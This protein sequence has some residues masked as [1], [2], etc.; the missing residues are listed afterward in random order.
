LNS[1]S[2][3]T[4]DDEDDTIEVVLTAEEMRRLSWAVREAYT[5]K[6]RHR[7][8]L[9]ALGAALVGIA[10]GI[11][12]SNAWR[13]AALHPLARRVTP[14]A[15]TTS[16]PA[17]ASHPAV[18][19]QAQMSQAPPVPHVTQV[20]QAS[21]APHVTLDPPV[22][23]RNPFDPQEVFEFPGGTTKAEARQKVTQLLLQ[24]AIDRRG[25]GT[26]AAD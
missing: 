14:A 11:A 24:R 9:V 12:A 4:P 22:R 6:R 21:Q 8:W 20:S 15:A 3:F 26:Q 2:T 5:S 13:P 1:Q 17:P 19:A 16:A 7:L 23:V 10:V 18:L 25:Q